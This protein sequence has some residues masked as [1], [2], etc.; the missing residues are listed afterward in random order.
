MEDNTVFDID[1]ELLA[2]FVDEALEGLAILDS[3]FVKL[4]AEPANLDTISA[5]FRPVHTV[6][7]NSAFFGLMKVKSLAHEME[8]LLDLA[9]QEKLVPNQDIIDI[10]LEGVD[11]LKEM[12][13]RTRDGQ[14]E[15]E[16]EAYFDELLKKIISAREGTESAKYNSAEWG[17]LFNKLEK[18]KTD[19]AELDSK[20]IEQLNEIIAVVN[21]LRA[22]NPVNDG[23]EQ[24]QNKTDSTTPK[25][26]QEIKTLLERCSDDGLS[27]TDAAIIL[28]N[29]TALTNLATSQE[30]TDIIKSALD[31]YHR[32]VGSGGT[33]DSLLVEL[34]QDKT[35][36]LLSIKDWKTASQSSKAKTGKPKT[37]S[38]EEKAKTA[39]D[40]RKTMRVTEDSIDNFLNYVGELIAVGEMYD[41][42]QKMVSASE[43]DN[44]LATEFRRVNETFNVL[45]DNLQKSIMEVR[46]VSVKTLL[47]KI[48]RM[49]R[50]IASH[51]GKQ[52]KVELIGEEIE[53]DKRLIETLDGPLTHMVRNAV[54]HGV[55]TPRDRQ[56]S[57]KPSEGKVRVAVTETPDDVT[58][59]ISDDGK[60]L[61]VEAINNK[62]VNLGLI[63]P[64]QQLTQDQI[65]DM[66]FTSGVSTAEKVTEVSGRGV[67]MDVVK[68]SITEANG[69]ITINTEPG[70]GTEFVIKLPKTV[71]TQI[72]TGFLVKLAGNRYVIPMDKVHEVFR[73]EPRQVSSVTERGLCVLRH[74]KLLPV[75]KL[76]DIFNISSTS[77]SCPDFQSQSFSSDR[78]NFDGIMVAA[79]AGNRPMA[80]YVDDVIGVQKVVLKELVGLEMNSQFYTAAAIMGDGTV[81]MVLDIVRLLGT[82]DAEK[83]EI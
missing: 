10:L 44:N 12:L 45:S 46:K 47:Q 77:S 8:T 1:P 66:I 69:K 50:D 14:P 53:V 35:E 43:A 51:S 9:K 64:D 76:A 65:I 7:G 31:E 79:K 19:F 2:G 17:N 26:L 73:P 82:I 20:Y 55:E 75:V 32:I 41:H 25:Q 13:T 33:G 37:A 27:D 48:P 71:S 58:L 81:A 23:S 21:R 3:L 40:V 62:A 57:G 56:A 83:I 67:G 34:L 22:D 60:G 54:D 78:Q 11:N 29:L 80:I 68:R 4:E 42:L 16:D 72:I 38:A 74:G 15:V 70:K 59:T 24:K 5:I 63:K 61:N 6:K 36:A 49:V 52:V 28:D 18:A 39:D 30:T